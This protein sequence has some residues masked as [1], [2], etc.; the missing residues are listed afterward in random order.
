[1]KKKKKKKKGLCGV[2]TKLFMIFFFKQEK[3]KKIEQIKRNR[4]KGVVMY[5]IHFTQAIIMGLNIT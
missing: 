2:T 5:T 3:K 4:N 1:M